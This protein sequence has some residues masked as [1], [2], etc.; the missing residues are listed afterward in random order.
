[1]WA[2][3]SEDKVLCKKSD[4][5]GTTTFFIKRLTINDKMKIIKILAYI[6]RLYASSFKNGLQHQIVLQR[7]KAVYEY[8]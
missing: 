6:I 2:R 3:L 1:M 5:L 8:V 4:V 7:S